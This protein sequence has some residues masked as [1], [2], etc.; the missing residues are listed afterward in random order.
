MEKQSI[1][2]VRNI[3]SELSDI[4]S[5]CAFDRL[6]VLTDQTTH[7]VCLPLIEK[8]LV[9]HQAH[10]ITIGTSDEHKTLES[11]ADVWQ[12][13]SDAKATRRS[14]LINLGGGMVTDLGGFAASTFK[15]GIRFLNIPTT[16][17]AMVDASVG[18]KTGINFNGLKNEIG[19]FRNAFDVLVD[20]HFLLTLDQENICSGFA[21]MLKHGLISNRSDWAELMN[22]DLEKPDLVVVKMDPDYAIELRDKYQ[23]IVGAFHWNKK[24]WSEVHFDT[25]VPDQLVYELIDHSLSEVLRKLPKKIQAE[26]AALQT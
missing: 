17:L 25:D 13:L 7:A 8:C 23:G 10:I 20:T 2:F 6:F 12:S 26:Y 22:F 19:V 4:L 16:L 5:A 1:L 15:R 3:E 14:L 18:G 11:L 9:A 24:Y 21:E